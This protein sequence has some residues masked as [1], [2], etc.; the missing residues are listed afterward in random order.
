MQQGAWILVLKAKKI[1]KRQMKTKFDLKKKRRK[2]WQWHA[3]VKQLLT[4]W[5]LILLKTGHSLAETHS[6]FLRADVCPNVNGKMKL[7]VLSPTWPN[8]WKKKVPSHG[9]QLPFL[10]YKMTSDTQIRGSHCWTHPCQQFDRF[11][12]PNVLSEWKYEK[13]V[14]TIS[15]IS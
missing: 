6:L 1:N 2:N 11:H 10:N 9:L 8:L 5:L 3:G 12:V 13:K 4:V 14:Q 7:L 15:L